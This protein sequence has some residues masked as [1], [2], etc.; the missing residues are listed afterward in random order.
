MV[1]KTLIKGVMEVETIEEVCI[2]MNCGMGLFQSLNDPMLVRKW[3]LI[4]TC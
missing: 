4:E 2:V 3:C 1:D